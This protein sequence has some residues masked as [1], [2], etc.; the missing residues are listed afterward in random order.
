MQLTWKDYENII[1]ED[2]ATQQSSELIAEQ[3]LELQANNIPVDLDWIRLKIEERS[4]KKSLAIFN[5]RLQKK[6]T[7]AE[8]YNPA[9]LDQILQQRNQNDRKTRRKK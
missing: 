9:Y 1:M 3:I 6:T 4:G 7:S 8:K 2:I 5:T